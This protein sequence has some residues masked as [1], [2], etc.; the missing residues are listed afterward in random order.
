MAQHTGQH[1]TVFTQPSDTEVVAARVF[2]APRQLVWDAHTKPE[3]VKQWQLGPEGWEMPVAELDV[4]PGG[5]WHYMWSK[6]G[7]GESL[8]M[9]GQFREVLEPERLVNTESWGPEWPPTV[10]T[11]TLAEKDG[12]T[13]LTLTILYISKEAR[14]AALGTGMADGMAESYDRLD[15]Y[16]RSLSAG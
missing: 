12:E 3:H 7:N 14:D 4:K 11:L 2:D 1:D 6:G 16:L 10:N 13:L 8:E 5:A 9:R 15:E